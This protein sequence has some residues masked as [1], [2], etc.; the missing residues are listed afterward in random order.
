MRQYRYRLLAPRLCRAALLFAG[1]VALAACP[2]SK[3][4]ESFNLQAAHDLFYQG[5]GPAILRSENS[6]SCAADGGRDGADAAAGAGAACRAEEEEEEEESYDHLRYPGVVPRTFLGPFVLSSVARAIAWAVPVRI[7]DVASHPLVVQFLVRLELLLFS[8]SAHV[9]LARSL[10]RYF[11]GPLTANYYLLIT[12]SQ[13]HIPFYSSR[14]L[15]NTFALLLVALAYAAWFDGRPRRAAAYL[16]FTAAVFR[17]DVAL[18]LLTVGLTMLLRRE[19]T[20]VQAIVTGVGS[21][22]LGLL[23]TVPLDSLLWGRLLWPELEV[24]WFNAV[25]NRSSEWGTQPWHWYLSTALPKALLLTAVLVPWAFATPPGL[26]DSGATARPPRER[27][28]PLLPYLAPACAFVALYSLLP[29]KEVRF[30]F[31]ALPAF[32][33]CAARGMERLHAAAFPRAAGRRRRGLLAAVLFLGAAGAVFGTL[34]GSLLFVRLSRDNYPGGAALARLRRHLDAAIP[35]CSPAGRERPAPEWEQVHVHIDV[36]AAMT[37]VSLFGQRH[38]SRR[39][40]ECEP[41]TG[42]FRIDKAGYEEEN[43]GEGT[44]ALYTHLLTER[45]SADGYHVVDV[46]QGHPKLDLRRFRLATRDAIFVLER[47]DWHQ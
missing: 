38:A 4:E 12:A 23:V 15:P 32:N 7:F 36:A 13:F 18:L 21:G 31:P 43:Q 22:L 1:L 2:H 39:W 16:V 33:A 11:G 27:D 10:E 17:C 14:L 28:P 42:P 35:P 19:I 40:T 45:P 29:H 30:I 34:L 26:R 8:W 20:L 24:W 6:S 37:G 44:A 41:S 47:D 5:L 3:V 46:A 9:R 25:D